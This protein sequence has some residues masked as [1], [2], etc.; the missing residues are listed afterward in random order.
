MATLGHRNLSLNTLTNIACIAGVNGEG[1]GIVWS[2]RNARKK[3]VE[4]HSILIKEPFSKKQI[5][6]ISSTVKIQKSKH[7]A[8]HT[9]VR[10][11]NLLAVPKFSRELGRLSNFNQSI[12]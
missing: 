2:A 10:S 5:I 8:T 6:L 3:G 7:D 11:A 9:Q 4:Q 1:V 12:N